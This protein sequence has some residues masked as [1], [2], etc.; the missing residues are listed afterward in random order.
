M[1]IR[2]STT[3]RRRARGQAVVEFAI[4]LPVLLGLAG[5]SSDFARIYQ[6][7]ISLSAATRD[8]AEFVAT[9]RSL[10]I[11]QA[12]AAQAAADVL[13]AQLG[14]GTFTAVSTLTCDTPQVQATYSSNSGAA[15]ATYTYPLGTAT[16]TAC[17]PFQTLFRYPFVPSEGL[18]IR[19]SARFE[20]L[21]NR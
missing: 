1:G 2:H 4:L 15:G 5:A 16:V 10:T 19:A 21:Q 14:A 13:N 20:V 7:D 11:T 8:A 17:L 18:V 3:G 6:K 9:N 12:N